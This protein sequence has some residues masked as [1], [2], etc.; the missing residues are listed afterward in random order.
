MEL[1]KEKSDRMKLEEKVMSPRSVQASKMLP[2]TDK[3]E[4]YFELNTD[5]SISI[6]VLFSARRKSNTSDAELL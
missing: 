2:Q 1:Q 6:F 3:T 4:R 5:L